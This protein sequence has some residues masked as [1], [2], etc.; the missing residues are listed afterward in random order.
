M[1]NKTFD[2]LMDG[3]KELHAKKNSDYASDDNPYSNFEFSAH[4]VSQF[5]DPVDQVFAGIIGIKI[6]RLGQLLG[7]GKTPKYESV[8]DTMRDLT[9]Y[10]GIWTSMRRDRQKP[11]PAAQILEHESEPF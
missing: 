10:C 5:T 7:K 3:L 2:E 9:N 4:L 6:A 1:K 8:D 11:I